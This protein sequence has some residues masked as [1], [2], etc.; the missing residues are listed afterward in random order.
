MNGTGVPPDSGV[1]QRENNGILEY[2]D[3]ESRGN[4]LLP[5]RPLRALPPA[6][7]RHADVAEPTAQ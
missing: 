3:V 7:P 1:E 6:N 2:I 5:P 4:Y